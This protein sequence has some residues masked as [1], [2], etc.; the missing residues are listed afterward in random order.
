M[1]PPESSRTFG[2]P[3]HAQTT[4]GVKGGINIANVDADVEG[5]PETAWVSGCATLISRELFDEIGLYDP[6]FFIWCDE[7]DLSLRA[8]KRGI[9]LHIAPA[10]I[11]Y[12][13]VGKSL[14]I[15]SPL[16]F[17]Y[18]MRNMMYLRKRYLKQPRRLLVWLA[19]LPRKLLQAVNL[20]LRTRKMIYLIAFVDAL[21]DRDGGIWKRQ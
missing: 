13:K 11:V 14:G 18:A 19:Y 5:F 16:T 2:N 9:P 8:S 3:L 6:V 15:V 7:W 17:F 4:L 10:S 20:S 1:L 12:H 21:T